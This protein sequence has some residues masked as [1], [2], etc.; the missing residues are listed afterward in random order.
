MADG[1]TYGLTFPF[2]DSFDGKYWVSIV[3]FT[4]EKIR[5]AYLPPFSPISNFD[6]INVR[7]Y[8]IQDGKP[9]VYFINIEA[10]K[11]LSAFLS[12]ML[13]SLPYEKS[14]ITRGDNFYRSNNSNKGFNCPAMN[15]LTKLNN[16]KSEFND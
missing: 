12:R 1:L 16:M 2:R 4:M 7:T 14:Q 15:Y 11:Y 10:G 5:P 9:G 6:E 13:S 3:A 8:V